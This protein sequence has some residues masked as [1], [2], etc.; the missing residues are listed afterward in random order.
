MKKT[1]LCTAAGAG[2][3]LGTASAQA[4]SVAVDWLQLASGATPG[5]FSLLDDGGAAVVGGKMTIASGVSFPGLPA[6]R[7]LNSQYWQTTPEAADSVNGSGAV[8]GFEVRVAP[9]GGAAS[10]TIEL[11]VPGGTQLVLA[12]GELYR[13]TGAFTSGVGISATGD[14]GSVPV[15]LME[16]LSWNDGLKAFSQ[17]LAWDGSTLSTVAGANGDSKVAF[18]SIGELDGASSKVT[19]SIPAAYASGTGDS[20]TFALG[21]VNVPEPGSLLLGA[22]GLAAAFGRRRR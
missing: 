18:F 21:L 16:I 11:T 1:I 22:A 12:V 8:S 3:A 4:A 9:I 2:L 19:L 6:A 15:Q 5:A 14:S 7:T 13:T 20:L 10:Y 17:D